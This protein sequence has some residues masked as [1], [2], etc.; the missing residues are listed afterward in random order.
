MLT[1]EWL[2]NKKRFISRIRARD[3]L[4]TYRNPQ[5]FDAPWKPR[6]DVGDN[7]LLH[8]GFSARFSPPPTLGSMLLSKPF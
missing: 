1:D 7:L 6:H 2:R 3:C 4:L 5:T 8:P